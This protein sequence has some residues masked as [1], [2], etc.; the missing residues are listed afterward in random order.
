MITL[1][2]SHVLAAT[3]EGASALGTLQVLALVGALAIGALVMTWRRKS[4]RSAATTHWAV[5]LA[6]HGA[7]AAAFHFGAALFHLGGALVIVAMAER[8]IWDVSDGVAE[9]IDRM[10][11]RLTND[12]DDD[13]D[14]PPVIP[15]YQ[16]PT[17]GEP[18]E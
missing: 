1:D 12:D 4:H 15:A 18:N 5:L 11:S 2:V 6:A 13:D 16:H 7:L 10:V 8:V 3:E 17:H 14:E 9:R